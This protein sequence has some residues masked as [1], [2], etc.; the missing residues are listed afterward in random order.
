MSRYDQQDRDQPFAEAVAVTLD[1]G[2]QAVIT[3]EPEDHLSEYF[4]RELSVSRHTDS[5]YKVETDGTTL[6]GPNPVPPTDPQ[7]SW[8]AFKPPETFSDRVTV[9]VTNVHASKTR[10]Y[11]VEMN[12]WERRPFPDEGGW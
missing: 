9:T 3:L 7:D 8:P 10:T 1:P 11:V 6:F 12:G 4:L 5:T 2:E